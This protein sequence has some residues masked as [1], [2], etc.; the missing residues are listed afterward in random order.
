MELQKIE[1][2]LARALAVPERAIEFEHRD[3]HWSNI[4]VP[5]TEEKSITFRM[6][7]E[8]YTISTAGVQVTL[9]DW[10]LSRMKQTVYKDLTGHGQL[11]TGR[12]AG[13]EPDG[14]EQ[15]D[16]YRDMQGRMPTGI[17][18]GS[19][20]PSTNV[21]GLAYLHRKLLSNKP[22]PGHGKEDRAAKLHLDSLREFKGLWPF[23]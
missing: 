12:G 2:G 21:C 14:D 5:R 16:A 3:M 19:F 23:P 6:G 4:L 1:K 9:I 11:L 7:T 20:Q 18:W 17:D 10:T 8:V 15:F 13:V 22:M